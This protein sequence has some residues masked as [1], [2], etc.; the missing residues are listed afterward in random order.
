[1]TAACNFAGA[2][3][4]SKAH[5]IAGA[6]DAAVNSRLGP[7]CPNLQGRFINHC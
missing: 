1:M 5:A 3:G 7:L 6:R 2:H 4:V